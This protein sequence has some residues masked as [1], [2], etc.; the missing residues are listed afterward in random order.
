M[1]GFDLSEAYD[2]RLGSNAITALYYGST[3]L[4]PK[5]DYSKEYL[6]I[7]AVDNGIIVSFEKNTTSISKDIQYSKNKS[8][9]TTISFTMSDYVAPQVVLNRGEKLYLKGNNSTYGYYDYPG[10]NQYYCNIKIMGLNKNVNLYGNIMSLLYTDNFINKTTLYSSY[11]FWHLFRDSNAIIDASNLILPATTL[12]SYCYSYMFKN[13]SSLTTAPELPAT[14]L[15]SYC[16]NYMFSYCSSLTTAPKLPATTLADA[17]YREMF[18][19]CDA[20]TSAPELPATTLAYYCYSNMFTNCRSLTT[21]P[22]LPA[23]TLADGCY[24]DMFYYCDAITSAPELPATTL[25]D[26]CYREMFAY[27]DAL[28]S[29]PELPAT[30]LVPYCYSYMFINCPSLNYIKCLATNISAT[31]CLYRWT[32]HVASTGTFVK[33]PNMTNWPTGTDGIPSGWTVQ[34]AS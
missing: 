19:Y 29:A 28:T 32:E 16:Y 24:N 23:T 18:A 5:R 26:G 15:A 1:N 8:H 17:C 13:C 31:N 4:W 22:E 25:T 6:T 10:A 14:T 30:T 7:E 21:A 34:D 27:C 2:I 12:A 9:W 20:L 33:N 3:L 11:T